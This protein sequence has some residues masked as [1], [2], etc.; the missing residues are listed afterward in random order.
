MTTEAIEPIIE[1]KITR[2]D[3][4]LALN[5]N[6]FSA[7]KQYGS[8]IKDLCVFIA[9]KY[10]NTKDLFENG[11]LDPH[12]FAAEFGY[13]REDLFR[14]IT[15]KDTIDGKIPFVNVN[16]K[17]YK[18]DTV[19]EYSLNLMGMINL[20]MS[21]GVK[22]N[23][24][25]DI[26][27]S[28][29]YIQILK[30]IDV[31][32]NE[33]YGEKKGKRVYYYKPSED[34][35][36][37]LMR[38]FVDVNIKLIP[39][40]RQGRLFDLYFYLLA[41]QN[42]LA[43]KHSKGQEEKGQPSFDFLCDIANVNYTDCKQRKFY[44]TKK[45]QKVITEAAMQIEFNWEGSGKFK[46]TPVFSIKTAPPSLPENSSF[47]RLELSY[48]RKAEDY[49]YDQINEGNFITWLNDNSQDLNIKINLYIKAYHLI[50]SQ[51]ITKEH[52]DVR[53]Y[54]KL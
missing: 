2:F 25:G 13:H 19:L 36:N 44:L 30:Q 12:E 18:L 31:T 50:F 27:M 17:K 52:K 24:S 6:D 32:V 34:F 33:K 26:N 38:C 49:Y 11:K 51:K 35:T 7:F 42:I 5:V 45:I 53:R 9:Y 22:D 46:Y 54:F 47:S 15:E 41:M 4:H 21:L 3:R 28:Y 43:F 10:N 1:N 37:N 40:F 14:T 20:R 48:K 23:S 29:S 16:G 8:L 39:P